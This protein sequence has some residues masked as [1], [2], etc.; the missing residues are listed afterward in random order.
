MPATMSGVSYK[1]HQSETGDGFTRAGSL[2]DDIPRDWKQT[3]FGIGP[4]SIQS[5]KPKSRLIYPLSIFGIGWIA[6]TALLL[7]YTAIATPPMIALHWLDLECTV[8]PTLYFD[9]VVDCFFLVDIVLNF[10]TGIFHSDDYIDDPKKVARFYLKG[11]FWFDC[12]TSFPISFVEL[13]IKAACEGANVDSERLRFVRAIKPVRWFKIARV[14]KIA[15]AGPLIHMMMDYWNISPKQ[16]KTISILTQLI[17]S[18]HLMAC[19]WWLFKVLFMTFEEIN[20]FLDDQAWGRH[21]RHSIHTPQGKIEAY[22]ISLYVTTMTITTVGYGDISA[23]NS[24]ERVGY[25][26]L[27]IA[28]ALIWGNLLAGLGEIHQAASKRDQ[29]KMARI[30][31]TLDFLVANDCPPNLRRSIIRWTR[32]SE[33]HADDNIQKKLVM[34]DLPKNL[35]RNLVQHLYS[36]QVNAVP[37]F[38]YIESLESASSVG[39]SRHFL[40]DIFCLLQYR[41]FA[42]G[43][44]CFRVC[45]GSFFMCLKLFVAHIK[46]GEVPGAGRF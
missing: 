33:E 20:Q 27:F 43:E 39:D 40:N 9:V 1:L 7:L 13:A 42:P 16:G 45:L 30:Q 22:I 34:A 24:S 18:I 11:M 32:F 17:M 41:T 25:I 2:G 44:V 6:V 10:F 4:E 15:K 19:A 14:M 37:L 46:G 21:E 26:A 38:A 3:L 28:G 8:I 5:G 31:K 35:R 36:K 29:E 23:D 12:I